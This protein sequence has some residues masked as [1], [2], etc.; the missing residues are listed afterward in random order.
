[1]QSLAGL[2]QSITLPV[3]VQPAL[4]ESSSLQKHDDAH[5]RQRRVY[6]GLQGPVQFDTSYTYSW[7]A[8][9]ERYRAAFPQACADMVRTYAERVAQHGYSLYDLQHVGAS[10]RLD[11]FRLRL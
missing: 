1:M 6:H 11:R 9:Y 3:V 7:I 8:K 4:P 2:Q 5:R 10:P